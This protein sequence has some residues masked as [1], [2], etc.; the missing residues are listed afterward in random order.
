MG[1]LA[2]N[3]A[4]ERTNSIQLRLAV[5]GLL[6]LVDNCFQTV[7]SREIEVL[8]C[9]YKEVSKKSWTPF[10]PHLYMCHLKNSPPKF[11]PVH[12]VT[13]VIKDAVAW[14]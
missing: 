7:G 4:R 13:F 12:S 14:T 1:S 8:L 2:G 6:G 5:E 11:V 3:G 10:L 9:Q